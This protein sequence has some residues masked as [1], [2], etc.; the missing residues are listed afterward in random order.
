MFAGV[1]VYP[2]IIQKIASPKEIL[3]VELGRDCCKWF[4]K[5][6]ILNKMEDKIRVIQGDVKKK[7]EGLRKFDVIM[8]ARPNLKESFLEYALG[9]SKKGTRIFYHAFCRDSELVDVK[10]QLVEEA[11]RLKRTVKIERVVK[12]GEIAPYKLRYRIDMIVGK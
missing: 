12:A 10:E 11:K 8:M 2:I 9:V 5:N 3:G 4:S 1:G 6:L 7:L